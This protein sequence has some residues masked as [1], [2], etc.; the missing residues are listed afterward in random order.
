MKSARDVGGI[1]YEQNCISRL[2][3]REE[4]SGPFFCNNLEV[5][6]TI[7]PLRSRGAHEHAH[8]TVPARL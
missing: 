6:L 3:I 1:L 4:K 5:A 8:E 7:A 2:I